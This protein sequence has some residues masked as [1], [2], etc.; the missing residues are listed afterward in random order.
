MK[1]WLFLGVIVGVLFLV[2]C[3][4]QWKNREYTFKEGFT[5]LATLDAKYNT[6]FKDEQLNKSMVPLDRVEPFIADLNKMR[7]NFRKIKNSS[8]KDALIDFIAV[9]ITMI[10]AEENFQKAQRIGDIGLASDGFSCSEV[11]YMLEASF[12]YNRSYAYTLKARSDL[13]TVLYE[14][15]KIPELHQLIGVSENKTWFYYFHLDN[16]KNILRANEIVVENFCKAEVVKK[17]E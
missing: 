12:Y 7:E 3:A 4:D 15:R 16:I 1:K 9:R 10:K 2:S 13:D 14:Y 11:P 17:E 8:E 6:S 5:E